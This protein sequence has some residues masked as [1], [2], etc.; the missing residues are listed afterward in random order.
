MLASP[1][2]EEILVRLK[3]DGRVSVAEVAA[4]LYVSD[5]TIRRDLK[6]LESRGLL[7]RIH[8]G[9]VMSRLDQE[10]PLPERDKLYTREKAK[11]A[12]LAEGLL[13]DGMS[14]FLD[15]GTTTLSLAR[16]LM[17]TRQLSVTTNSLDIAVLLGRHAGIRVSVTPGAVRAN[18]NALIGY[19]TVE[20][21]KNYFFD[22]AL[23]GI[24]ACDLG[25]GWMDYAEDESVL[26]RT[27]VEQS[28][29]SVLLAD[30]SKFNRR[31]SVRTFDLAEIKCVVCDC[32]PP[33][34]FE[35]AFENQGV[36][37]IHE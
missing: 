2:H 18:D 11:I 12:A 37:V 9:A 3:A 29:R 30:H 26:R 14:V 1:R 34:A 8:G 23:M 21:V 22:L 13:Q 6:E 7:R 28:G 4:S 24:A 17:T 33:E 25:Q 5:E 19:R 35:Q 15:T 16:R 27:L 10:Q 36:S 20:Y 32:R 31:A